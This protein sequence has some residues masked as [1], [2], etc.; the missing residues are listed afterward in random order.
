MNLTMSR[1][2]VCGVLLGAALSTG[3]AARLV[4]D[5][6]FVSGAVEARAGHGLRPESATPDT[7]LPPGVSLAD[8]LSEDD[9][10]AV[11][12][13]NNAEL[14]ATLAELGFARAD[15]VEAGLIRNPV[16]SL[17]FPL[18][19]KQLEATLTWPLEV[20]R[21]RPRR[22]AAARID[23]E[24]LAQRLVQ[25]GLDLVRDV[26]LAHAELV[27]AEEQERLTALARSLKGRIAGIGEARLRLGDVSAMEATAARL[28]AARADAEAA[29]SGHAVEAARDRLRTL[30]GLAGEEPPFASVAG[31]LPPEG[32]AELSA[33]LRQ[34]LVAR[35]D[36]RAAELGVEA[37]AE[38]AGLARSEVATLSGILDAN[39]A[40][41]E[42]F[43]LGPG[44]ALELPFFG[45]NRGR[46]ER[47]RAE[48]DHEA[49]RYAAARQ[50]IDLEVRQARTA[51]VEARDALALW[52]ER[53]VPAFEENA[54]RAESALAAG[55]VSTL[56][57]LLARGLLVDA[58]IRAAEAAAGVRR[59]AA[60]L[61]HGVGRSLER[62]PAPPALAAADVR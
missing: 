62:V 13:W 36:L 48:L 31:S 59:A 61:D 7:H 53:L 57:V 29:R 52:R 9:A 40:G 58:R 30:L 49:K 17:L 28:D 27:L 3:C 26:R 38:R 47:A 18:G 45:R 20:L 42:G 23:A 39:G 4:H 50:R 16:F 44:L 5:R 41:K 19:L 37:A 22:M 24:R 12:L 10:V 46:V 54:G 60:G 56:A 2:G 25:S 21:Q 34:A 43:E 32:P 8:G 14:S 35:P 33:L 55:E 51:L 1:A 6:G 15:L 11:A